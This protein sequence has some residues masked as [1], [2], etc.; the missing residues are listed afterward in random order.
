M[1]ADRKGI[2]YFGV[3]DQDHKILGLEIGHMMDEIINAFQDVLK[4][5]IKSDTGAL[6]KEEQDGVKLHFIQVKKQGHPTGLYVIEIEVE[7]KWMFCED[8][9][10]Y[11]KTWIEKPK[12]DFSDG[13]PKN[14]TT[15]F[16]VKPDEWKPQVRLC[17]R[18]TEVKNI[19]VH[20]IKE[21]LRKQYK[22]WEKANQG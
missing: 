22:A 13:S 18:T 2:I 9:M 21:D 17:G 1:N 10:Y 19:E 12:K 11:D 14:L 5:H 16:N 15:Y 6:S 20:A 8:K 4:G 7:R 3:G